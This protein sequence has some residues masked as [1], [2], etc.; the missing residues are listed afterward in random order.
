[1][2][3]IVSHPTGTKGRTCARPSGF[4]NIQCIGRSPLEHHHTIAT[5]QTGARPGIDHTRI[6]EHAVAD[7]EGIGTGAVHIDNRYIL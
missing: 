6:V 2:P 4:I 7:G 1:M 5:G 3:D